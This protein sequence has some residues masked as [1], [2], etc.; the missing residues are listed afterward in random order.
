MCEKV[1]F[2]IPTQCITTSKMSNSIQVKLP[3][4]NALSQSWM[5]LDPANRLT[6]GFVLLPFFCQQQT[7]VLHEQ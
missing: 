6:V 3:F 5:G 4:L 7:F 2:H 1:K